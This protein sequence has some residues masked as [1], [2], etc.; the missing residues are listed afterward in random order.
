MTC[1]RKRG[2]VSRLRRL[3]PHVRVRAAGRRAPPGAP[4]VG[5]RRICSWRLRSGATS[6]RRP[7]GR[8]GEEKELQWDAT[9]EGRDHRVRTVGEHDAIRPL[10]ERAANADE[11]GGRRRMPLFGPV[12]RICIGL[13]SLTLALVFVAE[14]VFRLVFGLPLLHDD[15]VVAQRARKATTE[16]LAIQ[17]AV[18]IQ[19]EDKDSIQRTIEA[20]SSR[21]GEVTVGRYPPQLRRCLPPDCRPRPLLGPAEGRQADDHPRPRADLRRQGPLGHGRGELPLGRAEDRHGLGEAPARAAARGDRRRRLSALLL[22]HAP[23]ARAPRSHQGD[24]RPRAQGARHTDRGRDRARHQRS[25]G[26]REPGVP[27]AARRGQGRPLGAP[28]VRDPV[29]AERARRRA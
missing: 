19:K 13:V 15:I 23:R 3:D 25:R 28:G 27:R 2:S 4:G 10:D 14:T 8:H 5:G 29:A 17:L 1:P 20:I 12:G 24:P 21:D 26:A 11:P 6:N 22:V 7:S 9:A 18:L 16:D